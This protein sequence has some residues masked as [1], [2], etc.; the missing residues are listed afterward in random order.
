MF[1][2]VF[3]SP[4]E[5]VGVV[6]S[7]STHCETNSTALI[8]NSELT[9]LNHIALI[10]HE[11]KQLTWS[12]IGLISGETMSTKFFSRVGS[13]QEYTMGKAIFNICLQELH[14]RFLC[15]TS[16]DMQGECCD[17]LEYYFL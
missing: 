17:K 2:V 3:L 6:L 14:A 4:H 12:F 9:S 16:S 13:T 5:T 11:F 7:L 15:A 10:P 8:S 1:W